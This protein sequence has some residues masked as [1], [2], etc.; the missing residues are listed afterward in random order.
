MEHRIDTFLSLPM[1]QITLTVFTLWGL[2]AVLTHRVLVPWIAGRE[3]NRLGR[4]EAEVVSLIGLAFGLL[5]SFNAV[6]VWET[7]D[8]ARDAV[9]REVAALEDAAYEVDV[10]P[11]PE[12]EQART[13]LADYVD[14]ILA[15]E[16]PLLSKGTARTERP[17]TLQTLLAFGRPEGRDDLHEAM[18][19]ATQARMD[20]IRMSMYRMSRARWGVVILLALLL[21][22]AMGLLHAEHRRGRAVALGFVSMSIAVCFVILFAHG[23]PF[24]GTNAIR[25]AEMRELAARLGPERVATSGRE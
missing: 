14:Y 6:T 8:A 3:G 9:V 12:R 7:G 2:F 21:I 25:P 13:A 23:R 22:V 1:W 5:I 11:S 20:R 17:E 10:L 18:N 15:D 19:T 16:W 24:I 4:F